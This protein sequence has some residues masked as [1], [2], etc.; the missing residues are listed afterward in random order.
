MMTKEQIDNSISFKNYKDTMRRVVKMYYPNAKDI[1]VDNALDYSINKRYKEFNVEL[2]NSYTHKCTN[3]TL[4]ELTDYINSREPIVTA[5]G[6]MFRKHGEVPNPMGKVIQNFL[7]LRD[8]DKKIMFSF[9]KGSEDFE[10]YNLFQQ[11]DKIDANGI[12]GLLGLYVSV[13]YNVNVATSITAQGR[14]LVSSAGLLFES[15]LANS[16][17]FGSLNEVVGFIDN[18]V[19]ERPERKFRDRDILDKDIEVEDCFAKV[20]LTCG[21]N[22]IPD[23]EEMDIIWKMLNNLDQED[24]NRIYYKNN[25][26]E[27]MSNTSMIKA[28]RYIMEKLDEPYLNPLKPPECIK[29]ELDTLT[30][31]LME[32]VYYHHQIIDRIDKMDRGIK[33]ICLISDTDSTIISLDAWYRFVL[34]YISDMDLKID[35]VQ[36]DAV[37]FL[38][39]DEFGD[40]TDER[41]GKAIKFM[42]PEYDFDFYNDEIVEMERTINPLKIIPQDNVRYAILN[43]ITYVLDKLVNDYMERVSINNHSYRGSQQCKIRMKSEFVF[44]RAL[45]TNV[46]KSYASI[47]EVQEGNMVPQ[48]QKASLDI[49]GI[50]SMAKSSMSDYTRNELKKIMYEDILN[51]DSIDQ[52]TVLKKIAILEKRIYQSLQDGSKDYYKPVK[53]KSISNYADPMSQQG[54]KASIAWNALKDDEYEPLNLD[55]RNTVDIAKV[56]INKETIEKVRDTNPGLY[57]RYMDFRESGQFKD[58]DINSL[59]IPKDVEVPKWVLDFIDYDTIINENVSGFPLESIGCMRLDNTNVNWTNMLKL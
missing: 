18:I 49:K 45:L 21:F 25:L 28:V 7:D 14:A 13:L 6:T 57:K 8:K 36:L 52:L 27:F 26:Y 29:A 37:Y 10:K 1:D 2:D 23:E 44:K 40:I 11:L 15:F 3:M 43:M 39:T 34:Q 20:I 59:A 4:L 58:P 12:Y 24:I 53:V 16:V 17:K 33:S 30:E 42:E 22:W 41:Y 48:T 47:I 54:I 56:V 50:A 55:E 38:E 46:K 5:Y 9:P 19:N 31:F 51:C 32:Y 35:K